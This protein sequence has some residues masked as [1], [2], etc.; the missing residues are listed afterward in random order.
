MTEDKTEMIL[1][2]QYGNCAALFFYECSS[3]SCGMECL[4]VDKIGTFLEFYTEILRRIYINV[5]KLYQDG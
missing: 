1:I 5:N 4:E 2:E 3:S